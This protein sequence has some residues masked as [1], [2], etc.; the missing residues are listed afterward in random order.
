MGGGK[1][2]VC[3]Y[4][5]PFELYHHGVKGQKWGVRRYQNKDGTLTAEGRARELKQLSKNGK[6]TIS[7]GTHLYRVAATNNPDNTSGTKMYATPDA[8]EHQVYRRT[9]GGRNIIQNGEAYVHK[10]IAKNNITIPS[11]RT[12]SKI[13]GN[14]VKDQ[15]VRREM[16]ESLMKKGMSREQAAKEVKYVNSG[17]EFLKSSPWLL[18]APF[19]PLAVVIPF[20]EVSNK[21]NRQLSLIRN[22][23][24]D[25]ENKVMNETFERKLSEK[26]YNAYRDLNDRRALKVK[27]PIVIANPD[28][29]T[30]FASSRKM[31]KD[32]YAR[33][34][35][36]SKMYYGGKKMSKDI[37]AEDFV[38]DGEKQYDQLKEL[39]VKYKQQKEDR[40]KWLKDHSKDLK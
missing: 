38:K 24:G 37:R 6:V 13:E 35:G 2:E 17:A 21:K 34:Y 27:N 22:S 9:I 28:K 4:Y 16:I 26:G 30:T 14:L 1:V 29:N 8:K 18:L 40:E 31:S 36:E 11:V 15:A 7:K 39:H 5:D 32:D 12:Q 20:Q 33:A 25:K 19:N 23:I 10:Y 3:V